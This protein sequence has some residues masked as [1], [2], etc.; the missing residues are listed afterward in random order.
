MDS[1]AGFV[2][3]LKKGNDVADEFRLTWSWTCDK[4]PPMSQPATSNIFNQIG[5]VSTGN[6]LANATA[7]A[8][9]SG[10]PVALALGNCS[11]N[12]GFFSFNNPSATETVQILTAVDGDVFAEARPGF[13]S[14]LIPVP[15]AF[16]PFIKATGSVDVVIT[17]SIIAR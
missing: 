11:G 17:Y 16:T 6:V 2:F 7:T 4:E 10:S 12:C 13:N 9:H 15:S 14:G 5:S 8:P 1:P 3:T